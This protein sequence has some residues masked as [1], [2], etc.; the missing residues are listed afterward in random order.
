MADS[1]EGSSPSSEN[2]SQELLTK[3]LLCL[4]F[5]EHERPTGLNS[6]SK[7]LRPPPF[8]PCIAFKLFQNYRLGAQSSEPGNTVPSRRRLCTTYFRMTIVCLFIIYVFCG[9]WSCAHRTNFSDATECSTDM[10]IYGYN[11]D[12]TPKL[13]CQ[14]YVLFRSEAMDFDTKPCNCFKG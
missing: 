3:R 2:Y 7:I 5:L 13:D 1:A 8:L 6:S 9:Y 12:R 14:R 4:C 10:S 11:V